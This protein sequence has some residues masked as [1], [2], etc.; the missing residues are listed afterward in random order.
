MGQ[1]LTVSCSS[2]RVALRHDSREYTP[3]NVQAGLSQENVYIK[4]C[5]DLESEFNQIFENS[6]TEHNSRQKRK[7]RMID[8]Y[9]EDINND[10]RIEKPAY[11]YVFQFGDM[12]SNPTFKT[13]QS[14]NKTFLAYTDTSTDT[15]RLLS[16]FG[17]DFEQINPNFKV[18]SAV[19]HMDEKT[20]HLH[21][22]F[23]PVATG[24][25][26]G[27]Q[28]RC[29]LTRALENMGYSRSDTKGNLSVT[30]WKT[31]ME[32]HL[33]NK[34]L[35]LNKGYQ[36]ERKSGRKERVEVEV[37]KD[38]C[39]EAEEQLNIIQNNVCKAQYD[40]FST[41]RELEPYEARKRLLKGE[42]EKLQQDIE[43]ANH[44]LSSIQ[45]EV[46]NQRKTLVELLSVPEGEKDLLIK[47]LQQK[48][49]Q[50][51][52]DAKFLSESVLEALQ[53]DQDIYLGKHP[54]FIYD[55]LD[56]NVQDIP[57]LNPA[58]KL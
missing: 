30:R 32:S 5:S 58:K 53:R 29:S 37:F 49:T 43:N 33:E 35:E 19:V 28:E 31:A 45:S 6:V 26:N 41:Q 22:T 16:E 44:Q 24:Y 3:D 52:E 34:L 7:D 18:V 48:A 8:N 14:E 46:E 4:T 42:Y 47:D 11:E 36:R 25:K 38:I 1:N 17:R 54:Q 2:G 57:N 56:Q 50:Y 20:P 10:S 40:L 51:F 27:M 9:F 39:S 12:Y 15:K 23:V 55:Y 13:V 21:V